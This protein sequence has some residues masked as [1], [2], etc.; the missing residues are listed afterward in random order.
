MAR[1]IERLV[2]RNVGLAAMRAKRRSESGED[3]KEGPRLPVITFSR[4]PAAG[5]TTIARH[6]AD[7]LGFA[8]WDQQLL[9]RIA[10]Q[11]HVVES[12][13][14]HVDERVSSSVHD[15]VRSLLVGDAY[16][17]DHYRTTL[18]KVVGSIALNGA[19]VIVGRGGHFILGAQR[20][21]RVRVVC[22]FD[23]R[24]RRMMY[25]DGISEAEAT[26]RV[27]EL[28]STIKN[29]MKHHFGQD[30]TA[31]HHYD[32]IVNSGA[33]DARQSAEL[34]VAAYQA[35]FRRRSVTMVPPRSGVNAVAGRDDE[36]DDLA[37]TA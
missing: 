17:Q 32:L 1:G 28:G 26:K 24:V 11:A 36:T 31:P 37:E 23:E 13:L 18:T 16:S 34:V 21:L 9:T 14:A 22:A 29:F 30:V 35:K 2:E 6:V 20:A 27:R 12:V 5:G 3:V 15:F 25:R 4:E 7:E 19:S 33:L 8:C 10:E